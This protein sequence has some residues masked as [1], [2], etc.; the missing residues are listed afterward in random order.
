MKEYGSY[1]DLNLEWIGKIPEHWKVK[2]V[3][4]NFSFRTGFTPPSGKTEYYQEGT[5][6]WIN[7]SD[8]QN[9]VVSDSVNKITDKAIEDFKPT[10]VPKGSL[11]YSFKLSVGRV[12]FNSLDCYTNEAIFSID[13][14]DST[15]LN[16][17]YYS[18]PDQIIRNSNENIYGAKILNQEL[19]KNAKLI[20]PPPEEQ[21]AIANYLDHKTAEIDELIADKKCLLELYE[22]EKAAI[23]N[24]AVTKGLDPNVPMK[25]SGIEWLGEIPEHWEVKKLKYIANLRSGS[26]IVSEQIKEDSF[27]PVF[28]GNGIRGFFDEYTHKGNYVLIGR[29]GAYCGNIQYATGRFWASEHAVVLTPRT[30]Y[31]FKY[32]GELLRIMNLNQYSVS[33]AQ[34]GLAVE[35]IKNLKIPYTPQ[36]EQNIIVHYIE[37]KYNLIDTKIAK[38]QKLIELLTE[39]R[40]A[41]ISEVVTGKIKVTD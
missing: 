16:F 39:Y 10:V 13:P 22:E 20:I 40:T 2:K 12:A 14:D 37:I 9:R 3:K 8:L 17:F 35:V 24:Q 25:D 5:N 19:I 28:G 6:V 33:A 34:P 11:L 4:Y 23:I 36:N 27:Y 21:T 31:Q 30:N 7:I 15:N 26:N 29:Q 38:T 41:L 18:L 32:L 1:K